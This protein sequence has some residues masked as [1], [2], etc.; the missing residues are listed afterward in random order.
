[1]HFAAQRNPRL[2]IDEQLRHRAAAIEAGQLGWMC[3]TTN[4]QRQ[5]NERRGNGGGGRGQAH[6]RRAQPPQARRISAWCFSTMSS[7][8]TSEA[9]VKAVPS[10]SLENQPL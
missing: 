2:A 5:R 9:S 10:H 1:M 6:A 8:F 3:D 7:A 4:E